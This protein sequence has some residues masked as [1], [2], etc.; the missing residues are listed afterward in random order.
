M[1]N[2][3]GEH[4]EKV[5]FKTIVILGY[6]EKLSKYLQERTKKKNIK[7]ELDLETHGDNRKSSD[8]IRP[9]RKQ[10]DIKDSM[11]D[12]ERFDSIDLRGPQFETNPLS[13]ENKGEYHKE[14]FTR[15][16]NN[17]DSSIDHGLNLSSPI[18]IS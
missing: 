17:D 11:L 16:N 9:S 14:H 5:R 6:F 10:E 12:G 8:K 7:S 13:E 4:F 15:L 18:E 2:E 3:T 1:K